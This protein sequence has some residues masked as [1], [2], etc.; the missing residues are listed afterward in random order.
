MTKSTPDYQ[1]PPDEFAKDYQNGD[2]E[3]G[4]MEVEASKRLAEFGKNQLSSP[5]TPKWLIF[6]RQFNNMI[7]Y[8]LLFAALLTI[9]MQHYSDAVIIGIVVVINAFIGYYQEISASNALAKIKAMMA[10]NASVYRDG[11]RIDIPATDLVVGDVVFLEAGD[12]VPADLRIVEADNLR[13][14]ESALTGEADSVEKTIESLPASQIALAD[15]HNM[16]FATTAVTNGSGLGVVVATA[17][18]TQIGQI[19]SAVQAVKPRKTPLMREIDQL[20]TGVSYVVLGAA[21]VLFALGL[22]LQI[23]AVSALALAVVTMI[24]GSMPEGLPATTSVIL[25]MGVSD[26]AKRQHAIIKTLPAVETLGSVDVIATDKTGTLTQNQMTVKD[27]IIDHEHLT[28][29]GDGYRPAGDILQ[30]NQPAPLTEK[31]DLFL[32]AG[33][34]ANDTVLVKTDDQYEINGE[35]TD[36]AFLTLFYKRHPFGEVTSETEIDMLPFDSDY[37]YM[38]KLVQL[39][40]GQKRLFIKGS[41][42]KLMPIA[43]GDF[44]QDYWNDTVKALSLEG[45]RVVAVGYR[46]VAADTMSV[47]HELIAEGIQ[48]L[49]VAGIIDPPQ[50]SVVTALA[51]MRR[52]GVAV[53]M[54][55]GDHPLTAKTIGE[56]LGLAENINVMTG[57]EW[58]QLSEV[59]HQAAVRDHQVF[60]RTTP[61]NKLEIVA[62]L[63][64]N[65]QVTA[66]TGDGVNDAPA[67]K[68]ADIGV[69][70]GIKG[71]DVAKDAA[72]MILTDDNFSTMS[73]AIREGRRIY[74]NI[75]KSILFLLPTSFAE[76]L[77]VALTILFQREMPLQAPQLLWINM[78]SAIT[79]QFAFIFEPAEAG[80]MMRPPRKTGSHLMN[81]HDVFQM[82]Y[83]SISMAAMGLFAYDWLLGM[84]AD[85]ATASTMMVNII[86]ISK[87]FYLFNIR[88]NALAFSKSFFSNPKA[89]L[90]IAAMI[91][92]QLILTYVPFMQGVFYTE[93]LTW[94]EWGG[95]VLFGTVPFLL[96]EADKII[97]HLLAKRS[98]N[99]AV[100]A[101]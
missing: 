74:D 93:P 25:A 37:R 23:Y 54:I 100:S 12:N 45:K 69:A 5:V 49:G 51:E 56:K 47:T 90:I 34:E 66:M 64:A 68:Q 28:V 1:R 76:G 85:Q 52:A 15:Q 32:R 70:M 13:I 63:Q 55:T 38:A 8:I 17:A 7:I 30:D 83:V 99:K 57:A 75:R 50:E 88:T 81:R 16:A 78:V 97:R 62:A 10:T 58:D 3:Q 67:L 72:D 96:A 40:N 53:K 86:V 11:N 29:T 61:K 65:D 92:L 6:I 48:F 87:I 2:F 71:T 21:V 43:Q 35:P 91:V 101:R 4:L 14:Q 22:F 26:M 79:I 77:I 24:V 44:D 84:G 33:F 36:G 39:D 46:D 82:A 18:D 41:P 59:D 80:L 60:A 89:F 98:T 31:L 42:D 19:S 95:A 94:M 20:G 9:L 73:A 27:I